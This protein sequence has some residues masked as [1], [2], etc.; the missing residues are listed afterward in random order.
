M[1]GAGIA[2]PSESMRVFV[3]PAITSPPVIVRTMPLPV[4]C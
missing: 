3:H 4:G 1:A 2:R